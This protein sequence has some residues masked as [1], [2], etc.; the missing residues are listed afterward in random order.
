MAGKIIP[1]QERRVSKEKEIA[2]LRGTRALLDLLDAKQSLLD[3]EK[4][5]L[6]A[7]DNLLASPAHFEQLEQIQTRTSLHVTQ[8]S[9][10]LNQALMIVS[11]HMETLRPEED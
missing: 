6:L 10:T 7:L 3:S 1:L 8:Y 11:A 4:S 5:V 2:W 9:L